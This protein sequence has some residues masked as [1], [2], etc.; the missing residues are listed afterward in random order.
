MANIDVAKANV[1][2]RDQASD[3]KVATKVAGQYTN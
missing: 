2:K 1:E 3:L